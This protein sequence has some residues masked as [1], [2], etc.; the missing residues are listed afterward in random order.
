[1][2]EGRETLK[3]SV[4][5][6]EPPSLRCLA[7]Q[8]GPFAPP[9]VVKPPAPAWSEDDDSRAKSF[10]KDEKLETASSR[11][12]FKVE[13]PAR[14]FGFADPEEIKKNIRAELLGEVKPYNVHDL[15][16]ESGFIQYIAKHDYFENITLA[17]ISFNAVYIA[18]DTDW[19]KED[20]LTST[21]SRDL[22]D[23]P[24][25][26]QLMEHLFCAYFTMEWII[27][28]LAFRNK[29]D[30]LWDAW[31]VFDSFMV[32]LMVGETWIMLVVASTMGLEGGSP[33]GNT[34]ILRLFRLLRLAR[35]MRMLRSLPELM[36]LIKGMV[37]AMT[38]VLYV[39][40]L[41]VMITY[42]FA[43][44]FTQLTSGAEAG[45]TYFANVALSMYSLL[46][47]ATFG[48]DLS[49]FAGALKTAD[50]W[51]C[52]AL[53]IVFICLASLTMMNMLVGVLCEVVS[54]VAA[55]E[56]EESLSMKVIET[57]KKVLETL[58]SNEDK[59]ISYKE[60]TGILEQPEALRCLKE[61][62]VDPMVCLDFADLFFFADGKPTELS[63]EEF[64]DVMMNLRE[65]N[66]AT[67][68]DLYNLWHQIKTYRQK[69][70]DGVQQSLENHCLRVEQ[71]MEEKYDRLEV[72]LSHL[73][74]ELRTMGGSPPPGNSMKWGSL[75]N[76]AP[77]TSSAAARRVTPAVYRRVP[78][79]KSR[80]RWG[81]PGAQ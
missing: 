52:L 12:A 81:G 28:F 33:L 9:D 5:T 6:L 42:V 54:A 41:L 63:F 74:T 45:E 13:S 55:S 19:N 8:G 26:F 10:C 17:V 4:S 37:K 71:K 21:G 2:E 62:G 80:D 23:S 36:I 78:N 50:L 14:L 77:A 18:V 58:D 16:H 65:S 32:I 34:G 79:H 11:R 57:M 43:I 20:P 30:S 25:F 75:S 31:F 46:I 35:L 29:C 27:R 3:R 24:L 15:Y 1:V 48:D 53:A 68:K 60:F 66:Q 67:V 51:P 40:G 69:D 73:L 38:S 47:H 72:Q 39:M 56:K 59:S 44:A 49:D 76:A 70:A 7:M 64:I 61:I 22:V